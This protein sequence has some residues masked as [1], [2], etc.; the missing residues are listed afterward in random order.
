V[1]LDLT[2]DPVD[3][4]PPKAGFVELGVRGYVRCN[5]RQLVTLEDRKGRR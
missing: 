3:M 2:S 4:L 1:A 5:S